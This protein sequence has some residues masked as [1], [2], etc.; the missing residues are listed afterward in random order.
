V[1]ATHSRPDDVGAPAAGQR[2]LSGVVPPLVTPFTDDGAV[3]HVSLRNLC[4][5]LL[6]RGVHGLFPCGTTG[7]FVLLTDAERRAIAETVIEATEGRVP[8]Y[9]QIGA[10]GTAQ[11]LELARHARAV[12]AD[13]VAAI[14]PYFHAYTDVALRRHFAALAEAVSPLPLYLYNLPACARNGI[15]SSLAADLQR[16]VPNIVGVKDSSGDLANLRS[17]CALPGFSVMSG[18]DGLGLAAL[19]AGCAGMVSGNANAAPEPFVDLWRASQAGDAAAAQAA[20]ARID[21]VRQVLAD[22]RSIAN[23]KAVL[24]AR[25]VLRS[26]AVR[27]PQEAGD[28]GRRLLAEIT[29]LTGT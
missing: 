28:D 16:D 4:Q 18:A 17:F 8:V 12:G 15:S 19:Q 27:A 14:T 7:E 10:A 22:G 11:A 6:V 9:V 23:F 26:A 21:A 24:V 13:G 3:D 20:Q 2:L 29:A 25:G 5:D 1:I